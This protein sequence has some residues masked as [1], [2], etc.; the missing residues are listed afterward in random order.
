[1]NPN[2]SLKCD[3]SLWTKK[4]MSFS[5]RTVHQLWGKKSE[6]VQALL[7]VLGFKNSFIMDMMFGW[8]KKTALRPSENWGITDCSFDHIELKEGIVIPYIKDK[9]LLKLFITGFD[10]NGP[11]K[12]VK[13]IGSSKEPVFW[14]NNSRYLLLAEDMLLSCYLKQEF[15][16]KFDIINV[17][18]DEIDND[19]LSES[20]FSSYKKI[21]SFS[22]ESEKMERFLKSSNVAEFIAVNPL[23]GGFDPDLILGQI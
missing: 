13:I 8:N 20:F 21:F 3:S 12:T 9:V 23:K 11:G 18:E 5:I 10:N 22:I 15:G 14:H 1:M 16:D 19:F 17:L 7:F 6:D 4:A 2:N